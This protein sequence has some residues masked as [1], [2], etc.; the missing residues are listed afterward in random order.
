MTATHCPYCGLQCAMTVSGDVPGRAAVTARDFPTN[1]G[2]LCQKGWTSAELL[3]HPDRL[4]TP[5]IRDDAGTLRPATWNIALDAVAEGI[6]RTRRRHGRDAVAVYGSGG[7]T[8]EKA[9]MLG[10]FARVAL[11]TASIDYNGRF[12]MSSAAA[13]AT[14]AFGIDRGLPF[15]V[16]DL[17]D[18]RAIILFGANIAETMPPL[19]G[20]LRCAAAAGG[21]VVV[22]PRR[23]PTAAAAEES[24]GIHLPLAPGTDA[25][26]ALG[27][28]HI[29]VTEGYI[30]HAFIDARTR[31]FDDAWSA[32]ARWWPHRVETVT[33]VSADALR[34]AVRILARSR[35]AGTGAYVLTGRGAE[36]HAHGTD[37]VSAV[38]DLALAMGLPGRR[39][40]GYGTVTGQGNGQGGREHGQKADQLPGYRRLSDALD[41]DHVAR[42]WGVPASS[43]PAPGVSAYE[44][45]DRAGMDR[46]VRA[47]LVHGANPAVSAPRSAHVVERLR[48][49]DLL[50]VSDFVLSE[51]A[52]MADVVL[53][54]LQWAEEDGTTTSLEGR[55][56]R[57]RRAV[58]PPP[59]ARSELRV[60]ADLAVRLGR[61][62]EMF[63]TEPRAVFDEL[64]RASSGGAADYAGISYSRLERGEALHWPCPA[65][66]HTGTPRLFLDRFATGDGRARFAGADHRGPGEATDDEHPLYATTGRILTQ[67]QSGAQTRRITELVDVAR[68]AFVQVH[69]DTADRSGVRDGALARVVGRRGAM[70]AR[71]R[72]DDAMRTDTVF[73]PFHFPGRGRANLLTNPL[74]DPT[75]RMPEFKVCA[76]RLEAAE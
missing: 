72:V 10:K 46:G 20:H 51:T 43:L 59:G 52:A 13:A 12:C 16:S 30:D 63:P 76:V 4:R 45:F 64:R 69:P 44:L 27:M 70:T 55:V 37:T 32:A 50:V 47:L 75:S 22:D 9:Y 54:V 23:T 53:P 74:L 68:E 14:R 58:S 67:Y 36:Q 21:L 5:L 25:A 17:T 7:L 39:G 6:W 62:A 31:G 41:R 71:V 26:L 57:R 11:G 65:E 1:R 2:G 19:L 34:R 40:R 28:L 15:P 66:N 18:A 61:P 48:S 3:A 38:I 56:L 42:V 35:D 33:G 8:N 24:G 73:V 60:L 29:A 49:L